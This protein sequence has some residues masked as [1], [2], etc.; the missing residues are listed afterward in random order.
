V[1]AYGGLEL[2]LG[3]ANGGGAQGGA[4]SALEWLGKGVGRAKSGSAGSSSAPEFKEKKRNTPTTRGFI[5]A[6]EG[7][8]RMRTSARGTVASSSVAR[9]VAAPGVAAL[10]RRQSTPPVQTL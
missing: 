2:V 4:A 9:R 5:H 3:G 10:L 1:E 7:G 8:L 6:T